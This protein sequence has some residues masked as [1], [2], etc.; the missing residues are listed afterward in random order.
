MARSEETRQNILS[1]ALD[2]FRRNG[3]EK[4]TMREIASEAGVALGSAYYYVDSK[5][6]GAGFLRAG[7]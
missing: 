3:F 4:T 7:Q 5:E 6:A 2:L 1:A